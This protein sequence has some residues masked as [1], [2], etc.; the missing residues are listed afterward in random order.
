M[1][2]IVLTLLVVLLSFLA[3]TD[4]GR[5]WVD[6]KFRAITNPRAKRLEFV[7][8]YRAPQGLR[9]KFAEENPSLTNQQI[10]R[11]F[12]ALGSYFLYCAHA[13]GHIIGM[14]SKIVDEAW[15]TFILFTAEYESFC[16]KGFNKFLHHTPAAVLSI[17]GTPGSAVLRTWRMA[18]EREGIN[19][20]QPTRL[21]DLFSLDAELE[22]EGGVYYILKEGKNITKS[23]DPN[24]PTVIPVSHLTKGL[25]HHDYVQ[26]H[27]VAARRDAGARCVAV[28]CGGGD[29]GAGG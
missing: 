18:C 13:P 7:A 24:A 5:S 4:K 23:D 25:E 12:D 28:L 10:D 6:S 14:P 27:G 21:P 9:Q 17:H 16:R 8:N 15:H 22:I 11:V 20:K 3:F 19:P 2:T 29:G 1:T 26:R